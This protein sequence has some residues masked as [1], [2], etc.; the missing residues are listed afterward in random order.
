MHATRRQY[1]QEFTSEEHRAG[2]GAPVGPSSN[3]ENELHGG[4]DPSPSHFSNSS[5][6]AVLLDEGFSSPAPLDWP[7]GSLIIAKYGDGK[8]ERDP[9][10]RL[11]GGYPSSWHASLNTKTGAVRDFLTL[12]LIL[13]HACRLATSKSCMETETLS[14][15]SNEEKPKLQPVRLAT[16][17][18]RALDGCCA[19]WVTESMDTREIYAFR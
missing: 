16:S 11:L 12:H 17:L 9:A 18:S 2:L 19:Y 4:T 7:G 8:R 13:P 3:W 6:C 15:S 1:H 5:C 14:S 10:V